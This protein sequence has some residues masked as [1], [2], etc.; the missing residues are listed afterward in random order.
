MRKAIV[1][2]GGQGSRLRPLTLT[3][4]KP[5]APMANRPVMAHIPEWLR[6]HGFAEVLVTLQG[7]QPLRAKG[8]CAT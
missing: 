5:L 3:R 1:M 7:A 4:T 2:A 8:R 6:R